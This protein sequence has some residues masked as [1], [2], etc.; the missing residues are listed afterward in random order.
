MC[1]CVCCGRCKCHPFRQCSS[2]SIDAKRHSKRSRNKK[3][4]DIKANRRRAVDIARTSYTT[5]FFRSGSSFMFR[6]LCMN[7]QMQMPLLSSMK[8]FN[9]FSIYYYL[10]TH[11]AQITIVYSWLGDMPQTHRFQL[12]S[13]SPIPL[14]WVSQIRGTHETAHR[15]KDRFWT[16]NGFYW[17]LSGFRWRERFTPVSFTL[18][19]DAM[20][21]EMNAIYMLSQYCRCM[22][23]AI[24]RNK[25]AKNYY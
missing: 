11:F 8:S 1:V 6:M 5:L 4:I 22:D 14:E 7:C 23:D 20:P 3:T 21:N 10:F 13:V 18:T 15:R 24:R 17:F 12:N 2:I 19:L 9:R 25:R 16:P